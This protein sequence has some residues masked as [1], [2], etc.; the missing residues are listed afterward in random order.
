MLCQAP[1]ACFAVSP[2]ANDPATSVLRLVPGL[3]PMDW[4]G[5]LIPE[6]SQREWV[7]HSQISSEGL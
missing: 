6:H 7:L 3:Y 4:T 5:H 1:L 2:A